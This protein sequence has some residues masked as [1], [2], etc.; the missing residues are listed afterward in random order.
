MKRF[1]CGLVA[2]S[3]LNGCATEWHTDQPVAPITYRV[4]AY[5]TERSVGNLRRLAILPVR[6]R[7]VDVFSLVTQSEKTDAGL[8]YQAVNYLSEQK[9]YEVVPIVDRAGEWRPEVILRSEFGSIDDIKTAWEQARSEGEIADVVKKT[10]RALNVD[11]VVLI[12]QEEKDKEV[13]ATEVVEIFVNVFPLFF[14]PMWY[15]LLHV[16]AE[17]LVYEALSGQVVW[18]NQFSGGGVQPLVSGFFEN[19]ENAIPAQLAK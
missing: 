3:F 15:A 8:T 7:H 16:G 12:W 13:N 6:V 1:L 14:T 17:A 4:P 5:R 10:G 11:G 19:L 9:G 2:A 18:R